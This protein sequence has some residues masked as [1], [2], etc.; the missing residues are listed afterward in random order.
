MRQKSEDGAPANKCGQHILGF[1]QS[2]RLGVAIGWKH[3]TEITQQLLP[4]IEGV[5]GVVAFKTYL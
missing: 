1:M 4:D 5:V 3:S 2:P